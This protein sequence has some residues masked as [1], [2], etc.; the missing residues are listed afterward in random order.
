MLLSAIW[1]GTPDDSR[2][3]LALIEDG[4]RRLAAWIDSGFPELAAFA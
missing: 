4:R 1:G 3:L 2:A